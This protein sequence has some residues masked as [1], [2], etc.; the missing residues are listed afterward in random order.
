MIDKKKYQY[1]KQQKKTNADNTQINNS[2]KQ[3]LVLW[4]SK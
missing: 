4:K 1:W 2:K 3:M